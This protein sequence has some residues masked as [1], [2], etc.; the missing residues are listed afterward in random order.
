ML[1]Y[2]VIIVLNQILIELSLTLIV[3]IV[4]E[5]QVTPISV[6]PLDSGVILLLMMHYTCAE[7]SAY[8]WTVH[9]DFSTSVS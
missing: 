1:K 9:L 6:T 8:V 4:P 7:V 2:H 3:F 5:S